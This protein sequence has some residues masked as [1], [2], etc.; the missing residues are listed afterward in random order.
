MYTRLLA[1]Q[2]VRGA[3]ATD[4]RADSAADEGKQRRVEETKTG[5]VREN[6]AK[7]PRTLSDR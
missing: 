7:R 1:P 6:V 4:G 3:D 5:K 2:E